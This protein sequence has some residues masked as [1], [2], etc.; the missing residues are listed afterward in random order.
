[1]TEQNT[2]ARMAKIKRSDLSPLINTKSKNLTAE[3]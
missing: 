1:M 3:H 2:D